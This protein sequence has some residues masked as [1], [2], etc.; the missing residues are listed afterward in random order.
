MAR[1][2][3]IKPEF[4]T[5]EKIVRLPFEARL[6]FIGL[7]NFCDDEGFLYE[8]SERIRM[9][10]LPNDD[11]D[12]EALLDLLVAAVLLERFSLSNGRGFALRIAHFLEHQKV[13]HPAPSRIAPE[14]SG[15]LAIPQEVRRQVAL[16]YGC[17]PGGRVD[18]ECYYCGQ[19]HTIWWP[20]TSKGVPGYW[21]SF[22]GLHLD[23]FEAESQGGVTSCDNLVLACAHCNKSKHDANGFSHIL[24]TLQRTPEGS[25]VL[26]PEG[27]IRESIEEQEEPPI[28][29]PELETEFI[30]RWNAASGVFPALGRTVPG[31]RRW[32]GS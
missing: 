8:Q 11:V 3:T 1:I 29:P 21:V 23:H 6:L 27:N 22:G 25:R 16:K 24:E 15:K 5:D 14:L 4:W 30:T 13:S 10:I 12:T 26:R 20:E 32:S 2:R 17:P 28:V 19:C 18:A 9:Q 31:S 7:W